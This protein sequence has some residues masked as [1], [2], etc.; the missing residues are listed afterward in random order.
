MAFSESLTVRILGDSSG[1]Q[2]ELSRVLQSIDDLH[3]RIESTTQATGQIGTALSRVSQ[4]TGPLQQVSSLLA[5]ISLQ[6]RSLSQQPV[7]LNVTPA[8]NSLQRLMQSISA[9]ASQLHNLAAASAVSSMPTFA[10]LVGPSVAAPNTRRMASGGLIVGPTG[11]DKIP[12]QLTAG[13]YVLNQQTVQTLGPSFVDQLNQRPESI[14]STTQLRSTIPWNDL[15]RNA[16]PSATSRTSFKA[17]HATASGHGANVSPVRA[18]HAS[19]A[20]NQTTSNHF[21]GIT[22]VVNQAG[23]VSE[24]VQRIEQQQRALRNRRG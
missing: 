15:Q 6:A 1:L 22:V 21:G 13:E 16:A 23:E 7:N 17:A 3:R 19:E 10:P 20:I 18:S 24:L 4:A 5:R 2:R 12:A 8:L 14:L 11:I 9:V